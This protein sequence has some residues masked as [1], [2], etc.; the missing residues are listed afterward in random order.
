[1]V[2][3]KTGQDYIVNKFKFIPAMTNIKVDESK[4]DVLAKAVYDASQS[5]DN[6]PWAYQYWP[7][8]IADTYLVGTAQEFFTNKSMT[9]TQF[10]TKLNDD[11]VAAGTKK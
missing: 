7:T 8:G 4:M 9:G 10:I 3:S 5:G 1:M 11:F 2:T 6:I